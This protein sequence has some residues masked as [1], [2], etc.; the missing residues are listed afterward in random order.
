VVQGMVV[1]AVGDYW[2]RSVIESAP[3]G[4]NGS[5]PVRNTKRKPRKPSAGR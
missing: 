3:R 4:K 1:L 2:M 5:A